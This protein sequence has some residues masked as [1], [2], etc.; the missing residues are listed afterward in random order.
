[1]NTDPLA[2]LAAAN[3]VAELPPVAPV[4]SLTCLRESTP[5]GAPRRRRRSRRLAVSAAAVA[6][7]LAAWTGLVLST[8]S[9]GPGV[10]VA[11]AAYAATSA[12]NGVI[13]A[14]FAIRS[15]L[16]GAA[17]PTLRHREW[18]DA[19]TG[20]RREQTIGPGEKVQTELALS[21]GWTEIWSTGPTAAGTIFRFKDQTRAEKTIKPSGLEFYRQLYEAGAVKLVGRQALGG[22]LLWKLEGDVGFTQRRR[23][24][25][26]Q[27]IFGEV[28]LV[29]PVTYL[30]VIE[31]QVDLTRPGHPAILETRLTHYRRVPQG[32]DSE[33]LVLLSAVHRGAPTIS[34]H[35]FVPLH[36]ARAQAE[37]SLRGHLTKVSGADTT[38]S[39]RSVSAI[40]AYAEDPAG[41]PPWGM[42]TLKTT[43]GLACIQ[44]GRVAAGQL[45][46]IGQDGAFANDGRFHPLAPQAIENPADCGPPHA[47]GQSR[48][49]AGAS[50]GTVLSVSSQGVP[51][52]GSPPDCSPPGDQETHP[53]PPICPEHDERA[54]FTGTLGPSARSITYATP[55]GQLR[56]IKLGADGAYL[57]VARVNPTLDQ[58]GANVSGPLPP[59][60]D[61]Q[62]I[63]RITYDNGSECKLE[64]TKETDN[65]G[66][67]C[68]AS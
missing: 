48:L 23:G 52:S 42:R 9:S 45:G 56:T 57:I 43:T 22:R 35:V 12:G 62:P 25:R 26:P 24:A 44:I 34:H 33:A 7:A 3:P 37:R 60:G 19:A 10:N 5:A 32:P 11:A 64:G 41:G 38:G 47:P 28:I 30:P 14:E 1:M 66:R 17:Q 63:Q 65:A 13:E 59:P 61:G 16:P 36:A 55:E 31:R 51:A 2:L 18:L 4:E 39:P 58:G 8:G 29:D 40:S 20:R 54:I 67:P 50:G 46:V 21:P 15:F 68:T 49:A 53:N 27:P 6:G